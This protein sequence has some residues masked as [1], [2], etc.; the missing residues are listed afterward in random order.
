MCIFVPPCDLYSRRMRELC[1]NRTA[2]DQRHNHVQLD[3]GN[4]V[5]ISQGE[6]AGE[7]LNV[8][9]SRTLG[10]WSNCIAV[11]PH[12]FSV[13]LVIFRVQIDAGRL[14]RGVAHVLLDKAQVG[15]GIGLMS[16][17]AMTEPVCGCALQCRGTRRIVRREHLGCASEHF[18]DN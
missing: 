10:V 15:T 12:G 1:A 14:D 18:L 5:R 7:R 16:R 11:L 8:G 6:S 3:I 17:R 9:I 2:D 4:K 13:S